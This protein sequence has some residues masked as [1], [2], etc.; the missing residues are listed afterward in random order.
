[1]V[2]FELLV[3][4]KS[5]VEFGPMVPRV[6]NFHAHEQGFENILVRFTDEVR[7]I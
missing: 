7:C 5:V 6:L 2:F 1:M 4:T 3:Q